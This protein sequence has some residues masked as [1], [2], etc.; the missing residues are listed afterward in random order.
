MLYLSRPLTGPLPREVRAA[1]VMSRVD[2]Y[3]RGGT[4]AARVGGNRRT[5]APCSYRTRSRHA[6]TASRITAWPSSSAASW[7]AITA[8]DPTE[9]LDA[10]L[11]DPEGGIVVSHHVMPSGQL[12]MSPTG[13][14]RVMRTS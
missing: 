12:T 5:A 7:R 11:G 14:R 10:V 2:Y 9:L 4:G 6:S 13:E 8:S 3:R 1:E